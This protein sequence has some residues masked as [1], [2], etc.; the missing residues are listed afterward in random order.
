MQGEGGGGQNFKKSVNLGNE[1]KKLHKCLI[2]M[3]K[4]KLSEQSKSEASK[5]NVSNKEKSI[6]HIKKL[7]KSK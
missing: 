3:L 7:S 4:I 5:N 2:L 1:W 6:K